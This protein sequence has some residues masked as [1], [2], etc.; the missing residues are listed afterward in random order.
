M[1]EIRNSP[2]FPLEYEGQVLAEALLQG[3][4]V[5]ATH[6][7]IRDFKMKTSDDLLC[8]REYK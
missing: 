6:R 1:Y 8:G 7:Y 5:L 2:D 4:S 3:V